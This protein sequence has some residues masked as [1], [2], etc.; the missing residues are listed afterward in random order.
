MPVQNVTLDISRLVS[1]FH[2]FYQF[3]NFTCARRNEYFD[4]C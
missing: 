4:K 1:Q 3:P 2:Q